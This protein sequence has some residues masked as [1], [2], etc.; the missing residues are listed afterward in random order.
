MKNNY[1]G[2]KNSM[3]RSNNGYYHSNGRRSVDSQYGVIHEHN[4]ASYNSNFSGRKNGNHHHLSNGRQTGQYLSNNNGH[5]QNKAYNNHQ[6]KPHQQQHQP[7]QPQLNTQQYYDQVMPQNFYGYP[8]SY[9]N[10]YFAAQQQ[11]QQFAQNTVQPTSLNSNGT[12]INSY[13]NQQNAL[14]PQTNY[15]GFNQNI[16]PSQYALAYQQ[17]QYTLNQHTQMNNLTAALTGNLQQPQQ[18]TNIGDLQLL[19]D[20]YYQEQQKFENN[21]M[22]NYEKFDTQD[23]VNNY[24]SQS[25][26]INN[27][28][29]LNV[30]VQYQQC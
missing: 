20:R 22:N 12:P 29:L 27:T 7:I 24:Q 1:R 26:L 8:F 2:G 15:A 5:S 4:N 30:N 9:T 11:Q 6:T 28:N 17:Y 3:N 21:L 25:Q 14:Q 18:Q 19:D 23:D 13:A 16:D 10:D